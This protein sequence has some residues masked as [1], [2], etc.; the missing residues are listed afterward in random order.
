MLIIEDIKSRIKN[1]KCRKFSLSDYNS[2]SITIDYLL[3]IPNQ[4]ESEAILRKL[5]NSAY[6]NIRIKSGQMV[7]LK[8]DSKDKGLMITNK[9]TYRPKLVD[10][11]DRGSDLLDVQV[12][13]N[14][15]GYEFKT[16]TLHISVSYPLVDF[17]ST[18]NYLNY[19]HQEWD[20]LFVQVRSDIL[21]AKI[22]KLSSDWDDLTSGKKIY[23]KKAKFGF[24][25]YPT[26]NEPIKNKELSII[27]KNIKL[28]EYLPF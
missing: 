13:G 6:I 1:S 25:E 16:K 3:R 27:K 7:S 8:Y 2:N 17:I 12:D 18:D 9:G 10:Y 5:E 14:I 4:V 26:L 24:D 28:E 22:N 21:L 19:L 15:N 23:N 20:R 11:K